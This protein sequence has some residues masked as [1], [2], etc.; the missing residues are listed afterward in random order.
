MQPAK[1]GFR[2]AAGDRTWG[3]SCTYQLPQPVRSINSKLDKATSGYDIDSH[4]VKYPISNSENERL[5][6][7][8]SGQ[9]L[10]IDK[11]SLRPRYLL[12]MKLLI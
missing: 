5:E 1:L 12:P 9:A 10:N 11:N 8:S 2:E 7:L 3:T 6:D 4:V